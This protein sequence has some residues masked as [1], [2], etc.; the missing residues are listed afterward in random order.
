M[1]ELGLKGS[2]RYYSWMGMLAVLI[3][4]GAVFYLRQLGFGL[5]ITGMSR[6]VVWGVY[7]GQFTFLAGVAASAVMVVLPYYLHRYQAFGRIT[8]LGE[9]IAIA[10][11]VMC[12]LFL[13]VDMG[14][15]SRVLNLLLYPTPSSL[16]FWDMIAMGG[17]LF[18]NIVIGRQ[19]LE[20]E[21]NFIR[22]PSWIKYLIYLSIPWAI[23]IHTITAFLYC[24]LPGRGFW[25]TAI[26][27]PR[28]LSSAFAS[29]PALLILLCLLV[30]R[31]TR[32]DP[33]K[34]SLQTL[35]DIVAYG[36]ILTVFFF[37]CEAFVAFYS[38]IPESMEHFT[39]LFFGLEGQKVMVPWMRTSLAL[40][41][42]GIILLM[43]PGVRRN[44][45]GLA[46]A[47]TAVF[48]GILI[49]K[50]VGI[51]SGGFIPSPLHQVNEYIPTG[52]ELVISLGVWSVGIFLL[53]FLF[54]IIISVR[55]ET[56]A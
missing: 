19:V 25:M 56:A 39:Y 29:G 16:L 22:P 17:Y 28:F 52:P 45:G 50:G 27:A 8:I 6:D 18:I 12:G 48:I 36:T 40:M 41:G 4:L 33:G 26:L 14:Q 55:E 30:R 5:G 21:R 13:F 44:E 34:G 23:G 15:P 10:S 46:V 7:I 38:K 47:C 42:L 3:G 31:L 35:A 32:F 51:I 11:L 2:G 24:G 43:T 54:K 20:A 9:G 49:D 1:F 53:T 37:I